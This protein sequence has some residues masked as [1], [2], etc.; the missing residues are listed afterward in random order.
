[1]P[2]VREICRD[3]YNAVYC[4]AVNRLNAEAAT[5]SRQGIV[6]EKKQEEIEK[7]AQKEAIKKTTVDTMRTF[8]REEASEIWKAVYEAHVHR[9]SGIDDADTIAKVVSADQS[10]KKSSGHAFE[11]MIKFLG[12]AALEGTNIEILLQKDLNILIKAG[13][14]ANEPRDISWLK[15]QIKSSVFDLYTIAIKEDGRKFCYGC[16]QSKTSVRDRVTRDREPSLQAM[17]SYFWSVA[18]VL[19]GYFLRLPK[20]ISMVN[21]GTTEYPQNGWHGMYVFSDQYSNGRIY[22]TDLEFANFKEHA[23]RAA[24]YWLTQRQWFDHDWSAE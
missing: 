22:A 6:S 7:E 12:N 20:F 13:E 24:D 19:D 10:W 5:H 2:T 14:I 1:M 23:V 18:V 9:K 3:T 15:E 4:D 17:A 8:P 21:G 16:I 11:E